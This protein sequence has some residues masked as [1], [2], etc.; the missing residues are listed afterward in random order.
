M[1]CPHCGIELKRIVQPGYKPLNQPDLVLYDHPNVDNCE[2]GSNWDDTLG[3]CGHT[4]TEQSWNERF[5]EYKN[6]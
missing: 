5:K 2:F 1:N 4:I 6:G 3:W